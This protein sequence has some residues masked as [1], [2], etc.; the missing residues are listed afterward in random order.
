VSH[1]D[2]KY[3]P[4]A[5]KKLR[6]EEHISIAPTRKVEENEATRE[7]LFKFRATLAKNF[8]SFDSSNTGTISKEKFEQGKSS[9][10]G[11]YNFQRFIIVDLISLH[12]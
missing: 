12:L 8:K 4:L 6:T 10:S 9:I 7:R 3:V 2:L 5:P 1:T 11:F